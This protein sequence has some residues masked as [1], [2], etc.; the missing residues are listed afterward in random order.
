MY[1][2]IWCFIDDMLR[3]GEVN[4]ALFDYGMEHRETTETPNLVVLL[5]M[6]IDQNAEG[7]SL[8]VQPRGVR[9]QKFLPWMTTHTLSS[10]KLVC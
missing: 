8:S 4:W 7:L 1:A 10:R 6:K 5:G 9:P 3:L 2:Q